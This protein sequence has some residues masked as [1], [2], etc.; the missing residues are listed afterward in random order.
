MKMCQKCPKEKYKKIS[1]KVTLEKV[2]KLQLN[3][4]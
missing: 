2:E 4:N 1:I 3:R